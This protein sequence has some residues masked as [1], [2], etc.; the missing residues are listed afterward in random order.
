MLRP[1]RFILVPALV[2][3]LSLPVP[4]RADYEAGKRAYESKV[5]VEAIK[6]LRPLAEAGDDRAQF[7]LGKMYLDGNGVISSPVEAMRLYRQ[8]AEKNNILAM[9]SIAGIYQGGIGYPKNAKLVN[10]WLGRAAQLGDQFA[11]NLYAVSLFQGDVT[12]KTDLKPDV[13][14][15][16][17]WWKIA[18]GMNTYPHVRDAAAEAAKLAMNRLNSVEIA[19]AEKEAAAWKPADPASLGPLPPEEE[20][21]EYKAPAPPAAPAK[22]PGQEPAKN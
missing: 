8:A 15:A 14:G 4:A 21:T 16:Y 10:A 3:V 17:K 19:K 7:L 11:A 22:A 13:L 6:E 12:Q 9:L 5:W 18:S 2:L 1:F 20:R